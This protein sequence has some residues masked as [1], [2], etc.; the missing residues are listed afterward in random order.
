MD[1]PKERL[2]GRD[3]PGR[4][5]DSEARLRMRFTPE[6]V[7]VVTRQNR[8]VLVQSTAW[9]IEDF[10]G[11]EIVE[12]VVP[13]A[14][15][16]PEVSESPSVSALPCFPV[17]LRIG[18]A[19]TSDSDVALPAFHSVA[20]AVADARQFWC[21]ADAITTVRPDGTI[22]GWNSGSADLY[23]YPEAE[24]AGK[25]LADL[26]PFERR[27]N[28]ERFRSD[29]LAG[30]AVAPYDTVRLR[31]DGTP[32]EVSVSV[33]PLHDPAG[34]IIGTLEIA[35]D[36]SGRRAE[37]RSLT[38]QIVS[39]EQSN[40]ELQDYA[41]TVAHDLQSPLNLVAAYFSELTAC[42]E[43]RLAAEKRELL[44]AA[45]NAV[46]R[47]QK[48]I[49]DLLALAQLDAAAGELAEVDC[50]A[51]LASVLANLEL[52]IRQSGAR[53]TASALP[54]VLANQTRLGQV[55]QNLISNALKF[56]R[57][58]A[59][60]IVVRAEKRAGEWRFSVSDNGIGID[61]AMIPKIFQPL[62]RLRPG[63]SFT[64]SGLGLAIAKKILTSFGGRLWAESQ[65][66]VGSIFY[67]T[68]PAP[69]STA[70]KDLQ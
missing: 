4:R 38:A 57:Q 63:G 29:A 47:M 23:G 27:S 43:G 65:P 70:V 58:A 15:R 3:V 55:F 19:P 36:I 45:S 11:R 2:Q 66:G 26:V 21:S 25:P 31:N 69:D 14:F 37:E 44:A 10:N 48:L 41:R 42:T 59:P 17:E 34:K 62:S 64:G 46:P 18:G 61:P 22:A 35:R 9:S 52:E 40:T 12:I 67:F 8:I 68:I 16:L 39:L 30:T 49:K 28:E 53:V 24:A 20:G 51:I 7:I 32:V 13:D 6:A 33:S 5:G 56:R 60:V 54:V 1:A 50:S